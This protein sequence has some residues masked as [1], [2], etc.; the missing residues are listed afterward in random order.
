MC[1]ITV[2]PLLQALVQGEEDG[3]ETNGSSDEGMFLEG[4]QN[5]TARVAIELKIHPE[6]DKAMTRSILHLVPVFGSTKTP[7][8]IR[9]YIHAYM[10]ACVHAYI[11]TYT[12]A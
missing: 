9:T 2:T 10:Y 6:I 8:N 3:Y 4:W 1:I 11:H 7:G 12:H 5:F